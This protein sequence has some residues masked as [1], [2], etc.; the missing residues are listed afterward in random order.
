[1]AG[2]PPKPVE[3]HLKEG[4]FRKDR[5]ELPV[6]IGRRELPA[7]P[8][9]LSV[10]QRELWELVVSDMSSS[11]VLQSTDRFAIEG[12]VIALDQAREANEIIRVE[13]LI[14]TGARGVLMKHPA[15]SIRKEAWNQVLAYALQLGLTPQARARLGLLAVT[16]LEKTK[17]LE[18][19]IGPNPLDG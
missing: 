19:S 11:G 17:R 1:M 16:G 13:G 2:R 18:D 14:T 6:V 7:L 10:S 8:D 3:Q 5:H 4:T 15:V 12:F 9:H